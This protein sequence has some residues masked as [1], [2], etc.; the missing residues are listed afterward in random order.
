MWVCIDGRVGN[1]AA[2]QNTEQVNCLLK[3]VYVEEKAEPEG[4]KKVGVM[5]TNVITSQN[6]KPIRR[7]RLGC[8]ASTNV[9][10][11]G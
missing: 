8:L 1:R 9:N 7:A 5:S 4:W 2:A 3:A 11:K 10:I 6:L